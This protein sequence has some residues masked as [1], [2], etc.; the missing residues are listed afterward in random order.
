MSKASKRPKGKVEVT[1]YFDSQDQADWFAAYWLDGG[2]L[3]HCF[4]NVERKAGTAYQ[5]PNCPKSYILK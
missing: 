1:M 5:C 2:Y 4:Y 3:D